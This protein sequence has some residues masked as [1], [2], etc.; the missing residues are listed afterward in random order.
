MLRTYIVRPG[1]RWFSRRAQSSSP[2]AGAAFVCALLAGAS[3]AVVP[4]APGYDAWSWLIWGRELVSSELSTAAGPAFK[5]LPVAACAILAAFGDAAPSLWVWC[6]RAAALLGV[7]LAGVLAWQLS[8]ASR[9]AAA[10]AAAGVAFAGGYLGLAAA[11]GS[12]G[13]LV[14]LALLAVLCARRG[15]P[16]AALICGV[17]C[18]LLRVETWPFLL[19]VAALAWRRRAVDRRLLGLALALVPVLW[20]APEWLGSGDPLRSAGRARL[21]NPGQPALAESPL[22][23]SLL[24]AAAV[25]LLP[26]LAGLAGLVLGGPHRPAA[27][28]LAAAGGIWV[29]LIAAMSEAGFS[30]EGR[31][32]LL[33]VV[34]LS[35]AG[36]VGL[37]QAAR[38]APPVARA[39]AAALIGSLVVLAA[40]PH[41]RTLPAERAAL[42][43]RARLAAE[44]GSTVK[45][46]GGAR[47]VLRCGRPYVGHLRGPLLAWHL[48]IH[49]R[50]VGFAASAPGVLFRSRLSSGGAITPP[51]SPEF[52]EVLTTPAWR[53]GTACG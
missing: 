16:R 7:V 4:G 14:A 20:L 25:P 28:L 26:L 39:G 19:V 50:R 2:L 21:A 51:P 23:A 31:Y 32:A 49:K 40:L 33:G 1:G 52:G 24:A 41:A 35:V 29:A 53:I 47:A 9:L 3:M 17:G 27:A 13:M 22:L 43:H 18:A 11:G 37:G 34:M 5:P 10:G 30:G 36:A 12:E 45:A 46:L 6:A 15:S 44:L 8:H 48:G 42:S 38:R